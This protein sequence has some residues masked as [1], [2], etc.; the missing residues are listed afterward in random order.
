[1]RTTNGMITDAPIPKSV[2]KITPTQPS[3]SN[4]SI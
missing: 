4:F 1:M 3:H 2:Y